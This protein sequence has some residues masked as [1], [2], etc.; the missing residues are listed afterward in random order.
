MAKYQDRISAV[1]ALIVSYSGH[2][3]LLV[4]FT[5]VVIQMMKDGEE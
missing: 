5:D 3:R 2:K 1:A 4:R